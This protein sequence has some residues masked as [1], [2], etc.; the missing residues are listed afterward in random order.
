MVVRMS[1]QPVHHPRSSSPFAAALSADW[2]RVVA[3]AAARRALRQ[4]HLPSLQLRCV[5]LDDLDD[6][7]A[8]A[9]HGRPLDDAE[10]DRVLHELVALAAGDDLAARVVLQRVLPALV[11]A[12]SRRAR[13]D[14]R[15]RDQALQ[16]ITASAWI[17]IRTYPLE[18]RPNRVASNIVRDS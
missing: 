1:M 3:S 12:A 9:G 4:W 18:R 16:E 17:V 15:S 13:S 7:V 6:L 5:D 8:A 14:R 10:A 2:D 11:A